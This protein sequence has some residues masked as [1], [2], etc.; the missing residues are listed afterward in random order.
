MLVLFN[1]KI[2]HCLLRLRLC[3]GETNPLRASLS[4]IFWISALQTFV[5]ASAK[6]KLALSLPSDYD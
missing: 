2:A 3:F 1:P 4:P 6:T 5:L